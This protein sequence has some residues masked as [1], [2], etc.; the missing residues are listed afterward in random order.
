MH[1]SVCSSPTLVDVVVEFNARGLTLILVVD[2]HLKGKIEVTSNFSLE[3]VFLSFYLKLAKTLFFFLS[4]L[5]ILHRKTF[6]HLLGKAKNYSNYS[7]DFNNGQLT[8]SSTIEQLNFL[9]KIQ[10]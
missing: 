9:K 8:S 7:L 1:L 4:A 5:L 2:K 3:S 10:I 6:M